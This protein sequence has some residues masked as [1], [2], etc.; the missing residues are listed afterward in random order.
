MSRQ[1]VTDFLVQLSTSSQVLAQFEA[2]P[3]GAVTAAG[4]TQE[5]ARAVL[6]RNPDAIRGLLAEA[7]KGVSPNVKKKK[8]PAKKK[9]QKPA[10]KRS[11]AKKK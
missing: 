5:E 4:L 7:A 3:I 6:S 10:K 1:Q 9:V 2:D 11:A 8:K